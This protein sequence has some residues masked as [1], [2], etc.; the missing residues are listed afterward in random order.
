[1]QDIAQ[2]QQ[3]GEEG[4]HRRP[5]KPPQSSW[6]KLGHDVRFGTIVGFLDV[7]GLNEVEV[8]QQANP[9]HAK[10]DMAPAHNDI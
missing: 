5:A 6:G 8:I 3:A 10:N 9:G 7:L 2:Q 4:E 1:M